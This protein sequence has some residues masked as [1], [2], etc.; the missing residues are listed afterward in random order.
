VFDPSPTLVFPELRGVYAAL[1]PVV[2][3]AMRVA[4][5]FCLIPHGLRMGFGYFPNSGGPV[6]SWRELAASLKKWGYPPPHTF[7]SVVIL[8]TELIGG[9]LLIL[10]LFTRVA[11][12]PIFIL[13]AMSIYDHVKDGWFWNT[14]GVEYPLIWTCAAAYFLVNGGGPYSLDRLWLGWEF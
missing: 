11:A 2:E 1:A 6:K 14:R 10:G 4:V 9:P 7:W 13:L 3:T 8:A 12:V 5:G